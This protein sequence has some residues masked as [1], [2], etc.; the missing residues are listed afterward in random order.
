MYDLKVLG[1]VN[2]N[3]KEIVHV[4]GGFG[5]G[6]KIILAK[7]I[8]VEHEVELKYV[9]KVINNNIARFNEN[10]LINLLSSSEEL[11][12]FAK[13]N[14]LIGSNRT[15]DVFVLSERGYVKF[16]SMMDNSNEKK[17]EVMDKLV[18]EYFTMR[19]IVKQDSYMIEDRLERAKRWIEEEEERRRLEAK[20]EE[21]KPMVQLA[22]VRIDKKGCFSITDVTKSEQLKRGQI[23]RWA[24]DKGY[25]HKTQTEVNKAGEKYFKV[26]SSDGKHN[27][28]GITEEGL[29]YI[30][31]NID[32]IRKF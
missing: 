32:E 20:V 22:E 15:Q 31:Q 12:N 1:K 18:D 17:W 16:V 26:Y 4:E 3:G 11:R 13:E 30:K 28:I 24:K 19:E 8:A 29:K 27:Q 23:T 21:Q 9:N 14:C 5:E 6:N 25:L 10:D 7:D 2:V